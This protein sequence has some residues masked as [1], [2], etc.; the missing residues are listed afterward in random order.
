MLAKSFLTLAAALVPLCSAC[1][2]NGPQGALVD[3]AGGG[4]GGDAQP[5]GGGASGNQSSA[6]EVTAGAA[7]GGS[8]DAKNDDSVFAPEGLNVVAHPGGC[9]A[10]NLVALTLTR[11][12]SHG[13]LYVALRNDRDTPACSP[14]FSVE[15]FDQAEQSL[16]TGLGGLLVRR[17]YRL[18]DGSGTVAACVGPGDVTMVAITDLPPEL[19]IADV[20]RVEYWCNYWS[21]DVMPVGNIG[22]GDVRT[23]ARGNEVAYAGTLVNGLDVTVGSPSVAIFQVNRVG[24]PLG[25]AFGN[26]TLEVPPGGSWAFETNSVGAAGVDH[27]DY[28][29]SGP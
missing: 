10:L 19:S 20:A 1:S 28:P 26:A 3:E 23:I 29:A 2:A 24:R 16:A 17:F 11:G 15:L 8:Y 4:H 27:A 14:A 12:P 21:L 6:G 22:I 5:V 7:A 25:V 9:G 18:T 13:E